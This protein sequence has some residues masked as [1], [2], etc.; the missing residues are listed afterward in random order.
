MSL[1]YIIDLDSNLNGFMVYRLTFSSF[2]FLWKN[3]V[4]SKYKWVDNMIMFGN[5]WFLKINS[6]TANFIVTLT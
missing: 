6:K 2:V 3:N 5:I 1:V 4:Q